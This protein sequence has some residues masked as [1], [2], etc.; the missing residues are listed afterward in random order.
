MGDA[1]RETTVLALR[2]LGLGDLLTGVPALR[3]LRRAFPTARVVLAAPEV[4]APLVTPTAAVD[5]LLPYAGLADPL[6]PGP[7]DV[8][9]NLHGCGPQSSAALDATRAVRR[10]GHR[11]FG[12]PGPCW[13]PE[14]PER[15]RWCRMLHWHG[16]EADPDDVLLGPP[17]TPSPVPAAVVVH[18]GAAYGAKRWPADRFAAVARALRRTGSPVVITGSAAEHS[19][20]AAVARAAGLSSGSVLAGRTGLGELAAL[21]AGAALLVC[22]DTGIAHL[23]SA[24]RTPSVV[25]FGPVPAARW[26]PP[27]TG[28]HVALSADELRRGD[29]FAPDP[30]PALLGVQVEDVLDA[31]GVRS[32]AVG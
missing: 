17:S 22:G 27:A 32:R 28:P 4:L 21:V 30:D 25:L 23:A 15:E 13:E 9:V 18:P 7:V 29:P 14:Q 11:G 1:V 24:Y 8:A 31:A 12:W 16:I 6:H 3:G 2:A 20:A 19:S 5:E 26:G 10:I